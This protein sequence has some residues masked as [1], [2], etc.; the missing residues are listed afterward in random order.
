M[1]KYILYFLILKWNINTHNPIVTS[2]I[3]QVNTPH[4]FFGIGM[5]YI[6]ALE[7][8]TVSDEYSYIDYVGGDFYFE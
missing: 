2:E 7:T 8:H 4:F 1:I 3:N 6:S 5:K